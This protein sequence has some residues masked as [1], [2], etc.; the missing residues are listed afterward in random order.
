MAL[1]STLALGFPWVA[2]KRKVRESEH[3][4]DISPAPV[5]LPPSKALLTWDALPYGCPK[6]GKAIAASCPGTSLSL[7]SSESL[8]QLS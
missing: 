5:P 3:A 6:G 1:F 4:P 7:F 2:E 8:A